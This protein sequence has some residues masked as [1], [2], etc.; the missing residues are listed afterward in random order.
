MKIT[1]E[2]VMADKRVKSD[3]KKPQT[4][5]ERQRSLTR[6][7]G[8]VA[9]LLLLAV[10]GV[11]VLSQFFNTPLLRA[12][13]ELV[14]RVITPVQNAF[15]GGTDFVVDYLRTLKLRGNLEA[16]YNILREKVDELTDQA[17][18]ANSLQQQLQAYADLDDELT[19]NVNL[20][21]IKANIIGRDT[22]NYTFTLTLDVGLNQGIQNNMA[23]VVPGALVGIT[24]DTKDD[25][26]L[27]KCIIDSNCSIA[28]IIESNR[29]PG[30]VSGTL[31][32]DGKQNCRMYY[33][34][35]TTLPR[36]GDIVVTSGMGLQLP[37][38]IPIGR[39]RES[40]RGL[41][42]SKQFIVLEP[43][44]DFDHIEYVIVYRYRSAGSFDRQ[45]DLPSEPTFIPLPSLRPVP[46]L[47]GQPVP[48]VSPDASLSPNPEITP[49]PP[50]T[51]P[52]SGGRTPVPF[53]GIEYNAP[54]IIDTTPTV[55]PSP[56]PITP[57]PSP[58][59][60]PG[61]LTVEDDG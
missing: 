23:V 57:S 44:A 56:P 5:A 49:S 61:E 4:N 12:P 13:R 3:R 38:G 58:S 2:R 54:A 6:L 29:D 32:I 15:A 21:G 25:S 7:L 42:D 33:L 8:T 36:P 40:T 37:K 24:Y 46:T 43:I 52:P 20:N 41:E 26:T 27:V 39:V 53:E 48:V 34:S 28:A 9:A 17:M 16:E 45:V 55:E 47:I 14:A 60:S 22:S 18:L 51:P 19:R 59:F 10:I 35:Y 30:T 50:P 31:A 1:K 11:M